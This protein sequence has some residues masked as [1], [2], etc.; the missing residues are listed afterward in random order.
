MG[1]SGWGYGDGM[2]DDDTGTAGDFEHPGNATPLEH[3]LDGMRDMPVGT[4]DPNIVG[5]AGPTDIPPGSDPERPERPDPADA[6][7]VAEDVPVVEP[8][9]RLGR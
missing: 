1:R 4:L 3:V 9:D 8:E 6:G 7:P 5:D 2:D